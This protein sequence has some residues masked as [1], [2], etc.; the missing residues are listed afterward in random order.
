MPFETPSSQPQ[1]L[2]VSE[3]THIIYLWQ[4]PCEK[5]TLKQNLTWQRKKDQEPQTL[6]YS[7]SSDA[8]YLIG[9]SSTQNISLLCC[10]QWNIWKVE[11]TERFMGFLG[12]SFYK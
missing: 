10:A 2:S 9:Q 12:G 7:N 11:M 1:S 8:D 4:Q 3:E 5:S 6:H